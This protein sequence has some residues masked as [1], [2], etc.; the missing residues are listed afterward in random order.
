MKTHEA[1]LFINRTEVIFW[2]DIIYRLLL[3]EK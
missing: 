3:I 2:T 1:F